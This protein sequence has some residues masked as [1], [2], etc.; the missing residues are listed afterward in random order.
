VTNLNLGSLQNNGGPTPTVLP[1]AGSAAINAVVCANAPPTDQRGL[2]RP[3]PDS[4]GSATRCDIG[5]V[6]VGSIPDE[7]FANGFDGTPTP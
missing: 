1:Q 7:I 5:A 6:E 2:I 3:D 4:A